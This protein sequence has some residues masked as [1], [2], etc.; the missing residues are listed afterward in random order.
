M[1]D[2]F[3][4]YKMIKWW[5]YNGM[6]YPTHRLDMMAY[7]YAKQTGCVGFSLDNVITQLDWM[8]SCGIIEMKKEDKRCYGH[9]V[10]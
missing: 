3:A 9:L 4:C 10:L 8:R 7:H 6:T 1:I 2:P 5:K